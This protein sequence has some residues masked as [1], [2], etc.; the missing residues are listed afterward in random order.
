M[1]LRDDAALLLLLM[2]LIIDA[3]AL[4]ITRADAPF[5]FRQPFSAISPFAMLC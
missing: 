2:M 1:I 5:R 3:I 4:L